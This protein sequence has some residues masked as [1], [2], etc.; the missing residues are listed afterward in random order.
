[1]TESRPIMC[2]L[3]ANDLRDRGKA[4]DKVLGSG[5]V[6]RERVHGGIALQAAPGAAAA[7]V[8][9]IDLERECCAWIDFKVDRDAVTGATSVLVT[10]EGD[11]ESTLAGMFLT[12][13]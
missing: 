5:L 9:L 3:D 4:W 6:T 10:A 13:S 7:L 8:E 12:A 11:G 1:M 2:T